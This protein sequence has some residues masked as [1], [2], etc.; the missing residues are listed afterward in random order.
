MNTTILLVDDDVS[1]RQS[2]ARVLDAEDFH[3]LSAANG[4]EA[5][6]ILQNQPVDL[7]LLDLNMPGKNGWE[8]FQHIS[9]DAPAVPVIIITARPNQL[10]TALAAGAAALMEKPL[11]FPKLLRTIRDLIAEPESVRC[12]R[13]AGK[14]AQFHYLPA[15]ATYAV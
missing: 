12:A 14:S 5:L 15:P 2:I 3:V 13:T 1:V 7:I 8:T 6:T 10:F 11:D 9:F 4:N